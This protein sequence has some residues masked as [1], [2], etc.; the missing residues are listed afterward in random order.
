MP[1]GRVGFKG[2]VFMAHTGHTKTM[3][4]FVERA[5]TAEGCIIALFVRHR[6]RRRKAWH[7]LYR[8]IR[9]LIDISTVALA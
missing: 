5:F 9:W 2:S 8:P 3:G 4:G 6:H 1:I 7:I